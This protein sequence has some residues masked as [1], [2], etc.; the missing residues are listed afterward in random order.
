MATYYMTRVY[1]NK[2]SLFIG[3]LTLT[4]HVFST[5]S[6]YCVT[7]LLRLN[8]CV[9]GTRP[10]LRRCRLLLLGDIEAV[11]SLLPLIGRVRCLSRAPLPTKVVQT[12]QQDASMMWANT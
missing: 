1:R 6:N 8:L 3:Y 5:V 12:W 2:N 7:F 9:R 11:T 4:T 10:A